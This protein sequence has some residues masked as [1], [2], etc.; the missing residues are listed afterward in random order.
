MHLIVDGYNVIHAWPD[1]RQQLRRGQWSS[2]VAALVG[3]VRVIHDH[4][5]CQLT[6]IF[7]GKGDKL[8][9]EHPGD[10]P[11]F[12]VVY[13]PSGVAAD[14][15]IEQLVNRLPRPEEATVASRDGLVV[16]TTA[17][18]GA[19][20]LS[21]EGLLEWIERCEVAQSDGL[22]RRRRSLEKEWKRQTPWDSLE[23]LF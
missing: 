11:T 8:Q 1:T 6:L 7:D 22:K 19:T 17:A 3:R 21:P 13:S 4:E 20:P 9:I 15:I 12:S 5:G 18:I 23:G 2:A 10:Q 16:E 14:T